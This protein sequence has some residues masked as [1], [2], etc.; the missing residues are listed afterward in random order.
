MR[1]SKKNLDLSITGDCT[2]AFLREVTDA[3][4]R[5]EQCAD[6]E[7]SRFASTYLLANITKKFVDENTDAPEV[8]RERAVVKWLAVE[9]RNAKTNHR[10]W[11][12]ESVFDGIGT[13]TAVLLKAS[14]YIRG[15][16]GSEPPVDILTR[17]DFSG[18]ASTSL[19]REEGVLARKFEGTL[20]VTPD[21]WKLLGPAVAELEGWQALNPRINTPR[22]VKGNVLF[23]VPKTAVIDRVCCKE[24][25]LNIFGQKAIGGFIRHRLRTR[26]RIDLNNQAINRDLAYKGSISRSL[27]TIDLSSASDSLSSG[28]VAYLLPTEWLKILDALRCAKTFI[29]GR[30]HVNEM[31]SSMGNGFTFEL[32]SLIFWALAKSVCY[33][34]GTRGRISVY[35]DDI[36]VPT[37]IAGSFCRVLNW[38]GFSTNVD[39]TFIRGPFRESCGG[40]YYGGCDVTPFFVRRPFKTESD[41]ILTLNQLRAWLIRTNLDGPG[42]ELVGIWQ[43]YARLVRKSL[44]GGWDVT[45][46]VQL[47]SPGRAMSTLVPLT[48][49]LKR[50]EEE[51]QLGLYLAALRQCGPLREPERVG[52]G[53]REPNPDIL[54]SSVRTPTGMYKL[55]RVKGPHPSV[56]GLVR[57]LFMVEQLSASG[58]APDGG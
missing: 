44:H 56:F 9:R 23:T 19:K 4:K 53:L 35:G 1:K 24:P 13:S 48:K 7:V 29:D 5:T 21:A 58:F 37:P 55:E 31:F 12:T 22:F 10:I 42:S 32:E 40:H 33:L 50:T 8:R 57:P 26:A 52:L 28:L 34:S 36:I 17:G 54:F 18:G 39:K 20:D 3:V 30:S 46:R 41:L 43:K 14:E 2:L 45:S 15:V 49:H 51:L 6:W 25:D 47:A 38:C 16:I 11:N 27:A